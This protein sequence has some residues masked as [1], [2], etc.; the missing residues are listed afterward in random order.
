MKALTGG[1]LVDILLV[2]FGGAL[3]QV[4]LEVVV[5]CEDFMDDQG[6]FADGSVSLEAEQAVFKVMRLGAHPLPPVLEVVEG[7]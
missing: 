2:L 3:R 7:R 6:V 4:E 1:G 5:G